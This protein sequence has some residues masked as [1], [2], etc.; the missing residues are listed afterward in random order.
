MDNPHFEIIVPLD[1]T[2]R[3]ADHSASFPCGGGH[4]RFGGRAF[5]LPKSEAAFAALCAVTGFLPESLYHDLFMVRGYCIMPNL[6]RGTV[7]LTLKYMA[8]HD[9]GATQDG[10]QT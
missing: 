10:G 8:A 1:P 2:G 4:A 3:P 7:E 5:I 6:A 9:E